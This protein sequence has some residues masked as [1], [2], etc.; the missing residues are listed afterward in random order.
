MIRHAIGFALVGVGSG[1]AGYLYGAMR[2]HALRDAAERDAAHW[3]A[4][5]DRLRRRN[6]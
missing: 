5:A 4:E 1:F 6:P 3:R 2:T